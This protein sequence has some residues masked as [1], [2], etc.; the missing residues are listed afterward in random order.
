MKK[1]IKILIIV[2]TA[3]V[4]FTV[5]LPVC[6][7]FILTSQYFCKKVIL[8]IAGSFSGTEIKAA[9]FSLSPM[10]SRLRI[11]D[12]SVSSKGKKLLAAGEIDL[13]W[14]LWEL[15]KKNI[16]IESLSASKIN[17]YIY[18]AD[19]GKS[20][21][22]GDSKT[23][24]KKTAPSSSIGL[25]G[26]VFRKIRIDDLNLEL[27]EGGKSKVDLK[28]FRI[29]I[30]EL[31]NGEEA[32]IEISGIIKAS[33]GEDI[34][35]SS[36]SLENKTMITLDKNFIPE[37]IASATVI[38]RI[39]GNI[40]KFSMDG[41]VF[42][43][44]AKAVRNNEKLHL[45][46]L[47]IKE[48]AGGQPIS[49]INLSGNVALSPMASEMEMDIKVN[50]L[51]PQLIDLIQ[52]FAG[53]KCKFTNAHITYS[54]HMSR[55]ENSFDTRGEIN[56]RGINVSRA[57]RK[58]SKP[59]DMNVKHDLSI[60]IAKQE[61]S[62]KTISAEI[63]ENKHKALE[64]SLSNPS[65]FS[66]EN[67]KTDKNINF[68]PKLQLRF[69]D[70]DLRILNLFFPADSMQ[71]ENGWI[72]GQ[73]AAQYKISENSIEMNLN[74]QISGL[75]AQSP[76][77]TAKDISI[78]KKGN[79]GI[80]NFSDIYSKG[81]EIE[82]RKANKVCAVIKTDSILKLE[83]LSG[84][85]SLEIPILTE[86]VIVLLPE[87]LRNIH[88]LKTTAAKLAPFNLSINAGT[89]F[90][91]ARNN[92]D[93]DTFAL[94]LKSR[95]SRV[96]TL[97][98]QE[99]ARLLP[100][101]SDWIDKTLKVRVN[102]DNLDLTIADS[103]IPPVADMFVSSGRL[104]ADI[105]TTLKSSAENMNYN[106]TL[107]IKGANVRCSQNIFTST[108]VRN[109]FNIDLT[110]YT[111]MKII[112]LETEAGQGGKKALSFSSTAEFDFPVSS[113]NIKLKLKSLNSLAIGL[114]PLEDI[115]KSISINSIDMTGDVK[116]SYNTQKEEISASA[117]FDISK[118]Q[119]EKLTRPLKSAIILDMAK[120]R[121]RLDI[122]KLSCNLTGNNEKMA[123]LT[124]RANLLMPPAK[125]KSVFYLNSE[126]IDISAIES[127]F[128]P[129]NDAYTTEQPLKSESVPADEKKSEKQNPVP[130][131]L[132]LEARVNL[133]N[134]SYGKELKGECSSLIK[135]KNGLV[136]ADPLKLILNGTQIN[137]NGEIDLSAKDDYPFAF[138]ADFK[139]L[140][141]PPIF[142]ELAKGGYGN[143]RGS[144]E[145]FSTSFKGKGFSVSAMEKN[146][147]GSLN[148][149]FKD[150]SIPN[151][152]RKD[153]YIALLFMS[154]EVLAKVQNSIP[155]LASSKA[156][157]DTLSFSNDL[158][159]NTKN[160][161]FST[162]EL[163]LV[164]ENSK[165]NIAKCLF[166]GAF[167]KELK[168]SGNIGFDKKLAIVSE[169]DINGLLLPL[170][171]GGTIEKP[172]P[173]IEAF[174][175]AFIEKNALNILKPQNIS[176]IIEGDLG[177]LLKGAGKLFKT[178]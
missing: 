26:F 109:T 60:D 16:A 126:R 13:S 78:S 134:I 46:R 32:K 135:I 29:L 125:G 122:R 142:K 58:A 63:T 45:E 31:K 3:L 160:L 25:N 112:S 79:I 72:N 132:E 157:S 150:L 69:N 97:L 30:P 151:E 2:F 49:D 52:G 163:K 18:Q 40:D 66:W 145:E 7:Y 95:N 172:K 174:I 147:S 98:L 35:I 104:T 1:K 74:T 137:C 115:R 130:E 90:D 129:K 133:K 114:I 8:P 15:L 100:G 88:E 177:G 116:F 139:G 21:I 159:S 28:K 47:S 37:K 48:L 120:S 34:K 80:K 107:Y 68:A 12:L 87:Y 56:C 113:A 156:L 5:I 149:D 124:I 70:F 136:R 119:N 39:S 164:T 55:K 96:L 146:F 24:P 38:N 81:L 64:L 73:S 168:I 77:C 67:K 17:I 62:L 108:D 143:T 85:A 89:S 141:L 41:Q 121:E 6:L 86:D 93:I 76:Y 99:K 42:T 165:V 65:L 10:K 158:S 106:G 123:D 140:Q 117:S 57:G 110:D 82:I 14:G 173:N 44:A 33:A 161:D 148:A 154:I 83:D 71:I 94:E 4:A 36:A 152:M 176:N 59:F 170:K 167:I 19:D 166:K 92:I 84:N 111:K 155:G 127:F 175:A 171:I 102:A 50:G 22:S 23:R 20:N 9:E 91:L 128:V 131:N 54:G 138:K 53:G 144:I 51:S 178:R 162:G 61:I 11:K 103:F 27:R 169:T 75:D 101:K 118:L 153:Q 43:I 105:M